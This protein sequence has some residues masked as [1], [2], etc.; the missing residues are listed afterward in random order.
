MNELATQLALDNSAMG[1]IVHEAE[2]GEGNDK[3]EESGEV[4]IHKELCCYL[5]SVEPWR[6]LT[7]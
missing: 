5:V 6:L 4:G 3:G 1:E 2:K 7:I